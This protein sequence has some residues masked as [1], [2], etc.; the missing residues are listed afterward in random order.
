MSI[1]TRKQNLAAL[2]AT[3]AHLDR[4]ETEYLKTDSVDDLY[5]WIPRL[6]ALRALRDELL[7]DIKE[8]ATE[9]EEEDSS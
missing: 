2:E 5:A 1:P 4:A 7:D 3:V 9:L 6:R 8:L